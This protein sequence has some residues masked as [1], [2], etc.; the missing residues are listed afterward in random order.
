MPHPPQLQSSRNETAAPRKVAVP[1]RI[2]STATVPVCNFFPAR[3]SRQKGRGI[4]DGDP[5]NIA[6][7]RCFWR[8]NLL[9][10]R[11][12]SGGRRQRKRA[13]MALHQTS[14]CP[15][16]AMRTHHGGSVRRLPLFG[17][18][19]LRARSLEQAPRWGSLRHPK[20]FFQFLD[21]IGPQF[22][23]RNARLLRHR[24]QLIA[25]NLPRARL[26]AVH[27]RPGLAKETSQLGL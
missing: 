6:D 11:H 21:K 19:G 9:R 3:Q 2:H 26:P 18:S 27:V 10:H 22:L 17:S 12:R 25:R 5:H 14:K 7:G 8:S 1:N 24:R 15:D 20:Q 13:H 23:G 16:P 4:A